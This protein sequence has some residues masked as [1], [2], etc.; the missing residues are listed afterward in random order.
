[1]RKAV[2]TRR[3]GTFPAAARA[4]I[5]DFSAMPSSVAS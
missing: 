5:T 3:G 1:L 4:R 2:S